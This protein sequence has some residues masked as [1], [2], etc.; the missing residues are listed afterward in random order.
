VAVVASY[1]SVSSIAIMFLQVTANNSPIALVTSNSQLFAVVG[2]I[3]LGLAYFAFRLRRSSQS[4]GRAV[5]VA[6]SVAAIALLA[7]LFSFLTVPSEPAH[8]KCPGIP[9]GS[10]NGPDYVGIALDIGSVLIAVLLVYLIISEWLR[11]RKRK[12]QKE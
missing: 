11:G 3:V 1:R 8:A 2:L 4:T 10:S 5:S 6:E 7:L 9:S 12:L